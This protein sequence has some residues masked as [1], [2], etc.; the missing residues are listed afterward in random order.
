MAHRS[1]E[2]WFWQEKLFVEI[3]KEKHGGE[4]VRSRSRCRLDVGW[5]AGCSREQ[6]RVLIIAFQML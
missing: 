5:R 3:E 6:W 4:T 1:S 2:Y